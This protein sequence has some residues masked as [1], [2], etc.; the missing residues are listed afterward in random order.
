MGLWLQGDNA[1][2]ANVS[3]TGNAIEVGNDQGITLSNVAGGTVS[4]NTLLE[5]AG[6]TTPPLIILQSGVNNVA[7]SGNLVSSVVDQNSGAT[8]NTVHNN[9]VVQSTDPTAGGYYSSTLLSKV[10]SLTAAQT[11]TTIE[12]GVTASAPV[13]VGPAVTAQP[14]LANLGGVAGQALI[15]DSNPNNL[16]GGAGNDTLVGNGGADT[17]TGGS[18]NDVYIVPNSLAKIV[19]QPNG[20]ID[21]VIAKGDHTLEANVENLVISNDNPSGWN[22]TGNALNNIIIGNSLN[23]VINGGDGNDTLDG[24]LGND[25]LVGGNGNDVLLGGG[26]TDTLTGGT[27]ADTFVIAQGF[28]TDRVTDFSQAQGDT[29]RSSAPTPPPRSEPTPSSPWPPATT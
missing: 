19:E 10:A 8:G 6:G 29:S 13:I 22:G 27:G 1:G 21:T 24:G 4:A 14:L 16:G 12:S 7:V 9:T 2:F 18:G 25:S 11:F 5:P 17:L 28:G 15:G 20:G 3:I 23:N 26:G